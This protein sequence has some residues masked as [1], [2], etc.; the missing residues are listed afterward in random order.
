M[1]TSVVTIDEIR[2]GGAPDRARELEYCRV[3]EE[4][5]ILLFPRT[6]FELP[7]ADRAFLLSQRQTDARYHKNIAYRPHRDRVTGVASRRA[8][9]VETLR[10]IFRDYSR[11]V[12]AFAGELFPT[13]ARRWRIDFASFRPQEEA[14]RRL[15]QRARNDLVHVDSFPTRPSMGDRL[16][17]VF[18]NINPAAPRVWLTGGTLE[19]LAAR[20]AT[21]SGLLESAR[22]G[23]LGRRLRGLARAVRLP[24]TIRSPYDDFMLSFHNFLKEN[25]AYQQEDAKTRLVFPPG[26]TWIVF[27]DMVSHAVLSGQFA[28]EQTVIVAR[29]S[30]ALPEKAPIA[31][32]ERLAGARLS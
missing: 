27:T 2:L 9:D 29:E 32:L 18:T 6:P 12:V 17:R 16:L 23:G 19:E 15:S 20:F 13:Y 5:H 11:R 25:A 7:E 1:S 4:G 31:I 21:S 10:R 8:E 24:V 30:L 3:L 14:G 26:S 28:L 22:R